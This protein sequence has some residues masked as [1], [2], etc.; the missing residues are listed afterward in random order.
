[1]DWSIKN[2][3]E[4][5]QNERV[6]THCGFIEILSPTVQYEKKSMAHLW[7]REGRWSDK[8]DEETLKDRLCQT[9]ENGQIQKQQFFQSLIYKK[10]SFL[11]PE[12]MGIH[13]M[14]L[15]LG[16]TKN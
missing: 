8:E 9:D 11:T 16:H 12:K 5:S 3:K 10:Y 6:A 1:M 13:I 4:S 15:M 7:S 14:H 2:T